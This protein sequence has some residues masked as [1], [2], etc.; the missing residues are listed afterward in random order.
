MFKTNLPLYIFILG[1]HFC[2]FSQE[3]ESVLNLINQVENEVDKIKKLELFDSVS[4]EISKL[5]SID[6]VF[7][8]K[9]YPKYELQYIALA[10]ELD[11]I[12]LAAFRTSRFTYFYLTSAGKPDSALVIVNNIIKD[13]LKIKKRK[14]LGHLYL[15]RAGANFQI[16][17]LKK[18]ILD[19]Q[20]AEKIYHQTKDSIFEADAI[21][22]NG[23][24]NERIGNL[25]QAIL[26]YQSARDLYAKLGDTSYVALTKIGES[27]IFSQLYLLDESFRVRQEIKALLNSKENKDYSV[28]SELSV[29]DSR[30][31]VKRKEFDKQEEALLKALELSKKQNQFPN[32]SFVVRSY[33]AEFYAKQGKPEIARKYLDTIQL[34]EDLV[35][36]PFD[37]IFYLKALGR[38][39]MAEG[40]YEDA[41]PVFEEE[42]KIFKKAN[43]IRGQVHIEKE[44]YEVNKKLN[45]HPQALVHL[46]RHLVLKD[47]IYNLTRSNSVIY[48]Q[49][50]YE[51]EKRDSKIAVQEANILALEAKNKAR[52]NLIIFGGI[53]LSLFFL[54]LYLYRNRILLI[55]NKKM[56][57][58]FLQELLQTQERVSK[59]I[60][61][62]LHDS[63][64]QSLLL[65]KSRVKQNN[66]EKT[67]QVVDGVIDEVRA[68]SRSLHPFKLE[69]LG[70]T[71]TLQSS[72]EMID[73][74]YDMFI[75]AEI[76]NIDEVFDQEKEIN[77]YRLVQE[78]FNNIL[79]HSNAR[80]AEIKVVN[81]ANNIE[82]VIKDNGKGFDVSKEKSSTS[83]IGLKTLSERSKF[84][85]ANFKILSEINQGTTLIFNIPKHV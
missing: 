61:K 76:D 7:Y 52:L 39:K 66:D 5:Q 27:N 59:R 32:Q 40:K 22:F 53:G 45:N 26:K 51:T 11:S 25:T 74:N 20:R 2:V 72:V 69:E 70:L 24:A 31:F 68:I 54:S 33:L 82:I 73:E 35:N 29:N 1:I 17:D 15:K 3:K 34:E 30:D 6:P 48:Y 37:R 23:Q 44:L 79:K 67:S 78:S 19:Y 36:S 84:L 58:S 65:V 57:Q 42:I 41:K 18:A 63:V 55:R 60:S 4:K 14:N 71:V 49:T 16:D 38:V 81:K 12:D 9:N 85:K 13:S 56:Q 46:D 83:K 77:I 8:K 21:F 43:D 47:S 28:L 62:D 50:L 10:R 64:G 75:S 80:S